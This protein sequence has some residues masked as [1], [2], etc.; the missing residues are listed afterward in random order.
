VA[1]FLKLILN[2]W[3]DWELEKMSCAELKE[4]IVSSNILKQHPTLTS[5]V[6]HNARAI[7]SM[8]TANK[9]VYMESGMGIGGNTHKYE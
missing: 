8:K 6:L 9:N 5:T 7:F 3:H 1:H 2:S 4:I